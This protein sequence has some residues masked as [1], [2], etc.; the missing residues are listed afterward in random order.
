V[1]RL[2]SDIVVNMRYA[3]AGFTLDVSRR[4][5]ARG[6]VTI[7][8]EPKA[9]D[10]LHLLLSNAG[11]VVSRDQL[12][13]VVWNGRIVSEAAISARIAAA[14]R[15]VG[16]DG[17]AQKVI[18]TVARRG[19]MLVADVSLNAGGADT[20][21]VMESLHK[22]TDPEIAIG[23]FSANSADAELCEVAADMREQLLA[24]LARRSGIVVIALDEPGGAENAHAYVLRG[25]LS[26]IKSSVRAVISLI[27][28]ENSQVTWSETYADDD[29]LNEFTDDVVRRVANALRVQINAHD[30]ERLAGV[31]EASLSPSELRAKAAQSFHEATFESHADAERFLRRALELEPDHPMS[32]TMLVYALSEPANARYERVSSDDEAWIFEATNTAVRLAPQSDFVFATRADMRNKIFGD[33][34]GAESD[35]RRALKINP[36]YNWGLETEGR[37]NLARG[38][39]SAAAASFDRAIACDERDPWLPRRYFLKA[40]AQFLSGNST[41]ATETVK[42]AL[43]LRPDS[44]AF[45]LLSAEIAADLNDLEVKRYAMS[46]AERLPAIPDFHAMWVNLPEA[47]KSILERFKP[48]QKGDGD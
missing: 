2:P 7:P 18:R 37:I 11:T 46:Q 9:F 27:L 21:P 3:F 28:R 6:D 22:A 43:E 47:A 36:N 30:G 8:I 33:L 44:R 40:L 42:E 20:A 23:P 39:Y 35:I 4:E 24:Q 32:L 15:A 31:P 12:V 5:L 41:Q 16:D 14:R 34:E 38:N 1:A 45:W 13:D 26:R 48:A 25:R 29:D 19:L 10:L 17:K